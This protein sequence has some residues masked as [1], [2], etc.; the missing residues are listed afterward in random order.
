MTTKIKTV[1]DAYSQLRISGLTSNPT[2]EDV[3]VALMR[4]ENMMAELPFSIGY[5]FEDEPEPNSLTN[6]ARTYW[7]MMATN[8]AVRLIP[9]FNKVAP[10]ALL[11][12]ASQSLSAAISKV[13]AENIRHVPYPNR[14]PLGSGNDLRQSYS[15]R[16]FP[17]AGIA[18]NEPGT[19]RV[20]AGDIND[21]MYGFSAFLN[22]GEVIASFV[23][24]PDSGLTLVSSSNTDISVL[25]RLKVEG[26]D[27]SIG[28]LRRVKVAI[29]TSDGRVSNEY[30]DF[31]VIE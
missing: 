23:V 16:Y 22:A 29:T 8:L 13:A 19:I 5:N 24:T 18:P 3:E 1:N 20:R 17:P 28:S 7:Q 9:D 11:M 21:H 14:Q 25:Y 30:V 12:Q 4:L 10:Q 27:V 26:S 2:P 31:E 6:V 15:Y